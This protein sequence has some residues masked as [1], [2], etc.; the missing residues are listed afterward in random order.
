MIL[1]SFSVIDM[2]GLYSHPDYL[3][4]LATFDSRQQWSVFHNV[5]LKVTNHRCPIC[6]C[7]LD[8]S[9]TRES[10]KGSTTLKPTIDHYRPKDD[11]LYPFLKFVHQNY[12]LMC[13]DCNN[14]Y[15]GNLFPLYNYGARARTIEALSTEQPLIVNP[16]VNDL[17]ARFMVVAR[18]TSTGK[19]VLELQAKENEGYLHAQANETIKVFSLG[20]IENNAHNSSSVRDCRIDLLNDHFK[21]FS[22]FITS[23]A[24]GNK[25][26]AFAEYEKY[27]LDS[28]G[29]TEFIRKK[30]FVD[31][32]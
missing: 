9:V 24:E 18:Y 19:K 13:S 27:Q 2:A 5:H 20:D 32:T 21:K 6:E 4:A 29:F 25:K 12:I 16:I 7:R 31:L 1:V 14:C 15:K 17:L 22:G 26:A 28:Y 10:K 3:A 30:Q 8:G 11:N 23:L